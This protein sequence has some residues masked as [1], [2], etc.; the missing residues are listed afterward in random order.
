MKADVAAAAVP[1]DHLLFTSEDALPGRGGLLPT[2]LRQ[3]LK[4]TAA[5]LEDDL[6]GGV[7]DRRE[8]VEPVPGGV[9]VDEGGHAR[10]S[11][12]V[13]GREDELDGLR[14]EELEVEL[15][16][17]L[18]VRRGQERARVREG[19]RRHEHP[20]RAKRFAA[21]ERHLEERAAMAARDGERFVAHDV[22]ARQLRRPGL[23]SHQ[24]PRRHVS[25]AALLMNPLRAR[26]RR[27]VWEAVRQRSRVRERLERHASLLRVAPH[28]LHP[29]T[30]LRAQHQMP[31][32]ME[33]WHPAQ[34]LKLP[35]SVDGTLRQR[36]PHRIGIGLACDS[37]LVEVCTEHL[38]RVPFL[39]WGL[40]LANQSHALKLK[41]PCEVPCRR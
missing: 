15:E 19:A 32:L 2:V 12:D 36:S 41:R 8:R 37:S 34:L 25:R 16:V 6:A 18:A 13:V 11:R 33:E 26:R 7:F 14:R 9:A 30:A 39:P 1:V 23:G 3:R 5:E 31:A 24:L 20:L 10:E 27:E 29:R 22:A 40:I 17:A 35:V 38:D 21:A 4:A 28:R